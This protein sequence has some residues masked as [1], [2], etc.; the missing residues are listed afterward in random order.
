MPRSSADGSMRSRARIHRASTVVGRPGSVPTLSTRGSSTRS[1]ASPVASHSS[2]SAG[3]DAGCSFRAPTSTCCSCT[4]TWMLP[5][6]PSWASR[7]WYPL[8]DQGW[9]VTPLVRTPAEC[10]EAARE[11]LDSRTAML[12][13]RVIAGRVGARQ[14]R[15]PTRW[16]PRWSAILRRSRTRSSRTAC[17]APRRP[18]RARPTCR[19]TSRMGSAACATSRHW[20]GSRARSASPW[21]GP[22][23]S[24]TRTSPRSTRR[25]SSSCVRGAPCSSRRANGSIGCPPTS[26]P[27]SQRAWGSTTNRGCPRSTG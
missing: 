2:R 8:W 17:G 9:T 13:G 1:R 24:G 18:A 26:S 7:L 10:V 4:T 20:G 22:A 15:R 5:C 27:R 14:P 19:P 3:T 11:R 16:S 21:T 25:R 6:S 12:D 23:S